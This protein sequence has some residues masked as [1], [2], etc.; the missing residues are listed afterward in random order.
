V[1]TQLATVS[2]LV[3]DYDEAIRWFVD[4]LG[5]ALVEDTILSSSKRWVRVAAPDGGSAL[6]L[7]KADGSNQV[8][9]I[10]KAAGGRV[11]YFLQT[12]DFDATYNSLLARGVQFREQPRLEIYGKVVVFN[13][14]YGN[15]WDLI[16]LFQS[17]TIR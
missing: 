14:L 1:S 3:R 7:A 15:G 16:E 5:F 9:A 17:G 6:L 8:D 10:G 2:Y 4:M 11:A 12:N 13:D